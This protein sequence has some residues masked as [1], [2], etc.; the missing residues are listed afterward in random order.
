MI[1]QTISHYRIV[2][3]L[4]GGGMGV[5]YKGEDTELGRFVAL[6]FLPD[7]VS[8]DAHALERFRREARAASA[9][10]HPNICTIY[11]I[12]KNGE[13][14]F[15]AMEYLEGLTLKHRIGG[16]PVDLETLLSLGIEI[17]D[18]L[19]AAHAQGIVHRDIKPAN[20]F[21]TKRGHAKILDFGL[22]KINASGSASQPE[23]ARTATLEAQNLTS[24]GAALG[25]VAY[26]SPEQVRGKDLDPRTDLFSFGIVLYEMATGTLPFRGDTSGII[27]DGILNRAPVSAVRL[28]PDL[29]SR[30]EDLITK[31]LEKDPKLRCQSAAEMRAD[32]ERLKRDSSSAQV[33]SAGAAGSPN[34]TSDSDIA[35]MQ[36]ALTPGSKP[37]TPQTGNRT[38]GLA[39]FLFL[40][41]AVISTLVFRSHLWNNG[42]A[43]T[44]FNKF[45]ISSITSSGDVTLARIS[46]DGR[47]LAYVAQ[48]KG[49]SGMWVR[50]IAT[51]IA[52]QVVPPT[53]DTIGDVTFTQDGDFIYYYVYT[54]ATQH[55][56]VSRVASLGGASRTVI[57]SSDSG[58]SFSPDGNHMVYAL[59]DKTDEVELE[60]ADGN[61]SGN[62]TLA[63]YKQGLAGNL[64]APAVAWSPDGRSIAVP[65]IEPSA[66]GKSAGLYL[67]DATTGQGMVAVGPRWRVI[68]DFQWLPDSSGLLLAAQERIGFPA[69]IWMVNRT[70][71]T[72]RRIS[73]DLNDYLSVSISSD[74]KKIASAQQN[75]STQVWAGPAATPD[76]LSQIT[77]SRKDI[78][79]VFT[80]DDRIVYLS[81]T[82]NGW[83][84]FVTETN[85]ANARQVS[86]DGQY[87]TT[88]AVCEKGASIFYDSD[89]EGTE[90]IWKTDLRSGASRRVTN[91]YGELNPKCAASSD[92]VYYIRQVPGE[93]THVFKMLPTG[94][95]ATRLSD[96]IS[97]SPPFVS[98]DGRWISFAGPDKQGA[99]VTTTISA[100]DG[101]VKA[102]NHVGN[103][104]D[105]SVRTGAWTPDSRIAIVDI[106]TGVP[107]LWATSIFKRAPDEQLT[108]FT[109]GIILSVAYSADG[110]WLAMIRGTQQSDAVLFSASK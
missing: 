110:K 72:P 109:S 66:D 27:F 42:L 85:G 51:S 74:G 26:M 107:N 30:L 49:H 46:P 78:R 103:T 83:D 8:G 76:R 62:R 35:G 73:S 60:I 13:R 98:L 91:G 95:N 48:S 79:V 81:N 2:E 25:T 101:S 97:I 63:S 4:G 19:D 106:R 90:H 32:L 54:S 87:R 43:Q 28:N 53:L 12:G 45:E 1:G 20:I 80:P 104:M 38:Y 3:K 37:F 69:Q 36:S 5:V 9:L 56:I 96:N 92:W 102:V 10:N 21:V 99:I 77:N 44:G 39:V 47:Y 58:V 29:P 22:A 15:I 14:S 65:K 33:A 55:G 41:A 75:Q 16:K 100:E 64:Y 23:A 71:G 52:V 24:P 57:A 7:E 40:L 6:K 11:E 108:H 94:E 84:V 18:A 31:A 86:Y 50:Q 93:G 105:S 70:N 68:N 34:A 89:Q 88:P 82:S 61:G 67:V 59:I 17:A